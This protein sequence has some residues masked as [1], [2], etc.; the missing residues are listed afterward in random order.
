MGAPARSLAVLA[1]I[2]VL[3]SCS[4]RF[5]SSVDA[6]S[7]AGSTP[8][9]FR[10][11]DGVR[12]AGRLF[13]APGAPAGVVLAHML[14]AD[15]TSWYPFA[16]RLAAQGYRV[17]TFDFRGYC[18][19]GDG[20]CSE[21][22]KQVDA[23]DVDLQAAVDRLRKDGVTRVAI[24]GASMGGT[25]A[26]RVAAT[27]PA[28]IAAVVTL[29]APVAIERLSVDRQTLANVRAP[30]LI[31]AGLGD[32]SGAAGAAETIAAQSPQ[33]VREEIVT[34]DAH[35]TDLLTSQQGEHVQELIELW[36]G[37]WLAP[38]APSPT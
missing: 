36:F 15:Q 20:G 8:I 3:A 6:A 29:S 38:S 12:L 27:D 13:G 19:G 28:G 5:S 26:L 7:L 21:G 25:A 4:A 37:Q 31:I 2:L 24:A 1:S 14:P 17:L 22:T 18:P 35:G 16:K 9:T 33:P 11:D 34:S 23:A 32:P 30:K 10:T